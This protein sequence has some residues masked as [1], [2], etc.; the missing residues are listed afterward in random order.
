MGGAVSYIGPKVETNGIFPVLNSVTAAYDLQRDTLE[1]QHQVG[2][3][4]GAGWS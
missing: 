4:V 1:L 2:N 3:F